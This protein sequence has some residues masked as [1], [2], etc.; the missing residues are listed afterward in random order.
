MQDW[1]GLEWLERLTRLIRNTQSCICYRQGYSGCGSRC[2]V[3][4]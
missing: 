2:G 1:A 3:A 4:G